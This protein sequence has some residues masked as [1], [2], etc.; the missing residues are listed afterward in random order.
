LTQIMNYLT[1][2]LVL[3][4]IIW[5][6]AIVVAGIWTR[7]PKDR[8][9]KPEPKKTK[10]VKVK[11]PLMKQISKMISETE[12]GKELSVPPVRTRQE[13]VTQLFESKMNAINLTP[14]KDSG[15]V[16]VSYTP[17]AR[18][19]K[20]RG[21]PDDTISAILAGLMEEEHE[22]EVRDIIDATA[23]SPD[24]NLVGNE[25]D[26]AKELAVEEWKNLRKSGNT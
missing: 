17:L 14:S 18:F 2:P 15:Y 20:E 21:V 11:G 8:A 19:L 26:K 24:V 7:R 16:P 13:I 3:I 5:I 6:V 4:V 25:L 9:S 23:D 1:D 10:V 22:A 12:K